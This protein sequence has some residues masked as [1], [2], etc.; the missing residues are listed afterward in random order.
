MAELFASYLLADGREVLLLEHLPRIGIDESVEEFGTFVDALA[1][2]NATAD[3]HLPMTSATW[4]IDWL[5]VTRTA[6]GYARS[7]RWGE[8]LVQSAAILDHLWTDI[9]KLVLAI[10]QELALL[11]LDACHQDPL[12]GNCGWRAD[13]T[14]VLIDCA[15]VSRF[16]ALYD[17]AIC[18]G[19][20][21]QPWPS[22]HG[23]EPWIAR[24]CETYN[25]RSA[26]QLTRAMAERA[27]N[28][29]LSASVVWLD[30]RTFHRTDQKLCEAAAAGNTENGW[31]DWFARTWR[32]IERMCKEGITG[33][34]A[35]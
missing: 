28:L 11:P 22:T 19:A 16:P 29:Q 21:N 5:S 26:Y 8:P 33:E 34:L 23:R 4:L 24:Y 10:Q 20:C 32:R 14:L 17:L 3:A 27:V 7:G 6:W 1:R 2:F 15:Y 9:D 25:R 31:G 35:G 12:Y 18:L 30:E 13:G